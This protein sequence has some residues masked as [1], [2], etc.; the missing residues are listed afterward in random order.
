M[1][2]LA[3]DSNKEAGFDEIIYAEESNFNYIIKNLYE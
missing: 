2:K 1:I 3:N